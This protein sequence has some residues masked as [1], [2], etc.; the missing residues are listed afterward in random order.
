MA[1]DPR[2]VIAPSL[3]MYFVDKDSGLP[4]VNGQVFFFEDE[5]RT[6]PKDV[7][8]ISGAPPNYQYNV[9][10]NPVSLSSVGTFE[11]ANGNDVL[12]YYFPFDS[13]GNVQLYY[14]EVYDSMGVLQFTREGWPNFTTTE[15]TSSQDVT[16]FVPNG[17]FLLHD[18]VP[19]SSAN[20]FI[21]G[22]LS[23]DVT[24]IAQGGWTFERGPSSTATDF[25]TFPKYTSYT[26]SPS[27]NPLFA[28]QYTTTIAGS[29]TRKDVCLKFPNVNTFASDTQSYNFYFE[30]QSLTGGSINNIQII[31]RKFF[32]TGGSPTATSETVITSITLTPA[33]AKFNT[34]ILFGT[35]AAATIGTNGD[36]YVQICLRFPPT[37]V[38]SAKVTDF[39]LTVN[40]EPLASF[41]QQTEAQQLDPSTA[42]WFPVPNPDGSDLY[43]PAVLGV[44]GLLFDHSSI[45]EIVGL[46]VTP[47]RATGNLLY[48]DG[49]SYLTADYSSLAIPYSRLQAILF[50]ATPNGPL[51]GTG[52]NFVNTNDST[53]SPAQLILTTNKTGAQTNPVD[54]TTA[55]GF[56]FNTAVNTGTAGLS[57]NAYANLTGVVTAVETSQGVVT[58]GISA[59]TSGFGVANLSQT[60]IAAP[61]YSFEVIPVSAAALTTGGTGLYFDFSSTAVNYRMWFHV[62]AETA[63]A[64]GGRTLVQCNLTS[65]MSAADVGLTIANVITGHQTNTITIAGQPAAAGS[66]FNFT[67]NSV[68]Y[69]VWYQINGVG[70]A[71]T[72][73]FAQVIKVILTG[74]ENA[75]QVA[76]K[77]QTAINSQYFAVPDLRGYFLRGTDPTS[78]VDLGASARYAYYAA[79]LS[80]Y[81]GTYE[82]DQFSQHYH[83][84]GNQSPTTGAG[85]GS[86]GAGT[87]TGNTGGGENNPVNVTVN[88]FI[89]Y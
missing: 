22:K 27:G 75:I 36:D 39:A 33:V 86:S 88:Y 61:Y 23:Q 64:A 20:T 44:S 73:P 24:V 49:T 59:G 50:N 72:Q 71:P 45:G 40:N 52:V 62:S 38:Q 78:V 79:A 9:L 11:D 1:L 26:S 68:I 69:Y 46:M 74:A 8:E 28:L 63:P 54:G 66:F 67:A 87:T 80:S 56:V 7:F 10:P 5:A 43:C 58:L 60:G 41:P 31:V 13:L 21:V 4:L 15:V 48:C 14:I 6:I 47:A 57:F 17:Q 77:T 53:G 51:F 18:N 3:Q 65:T 55:T 76:T 82:R 37:S 89:R 16:N 19:A 34:A 35:N 83:A 42:G 81:L 30:G 85:S 32:G 25:I 12:P 29:D 70:T 84:L 2:Y